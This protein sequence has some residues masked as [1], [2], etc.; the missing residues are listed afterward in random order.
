MTSNGKSKWSIKCIKLKDRKEIV[1]RKE[2]N[3]QEGNNNNN[4][5]NT[6]SAFAS[7]EREMSL[8]QEGKEFVCFYVCSSNGN[9]FSA[10]Y[11]FEREKLCDMRNEILIWISWWFL[12]KNRRVHSSMDASYIF[13]GYHLFFFWLFCY[14]FNHHH[15]PLRHRNCRW[16]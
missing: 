15:H 1:D 2:G 16:P 4:D 7:V 11:F 5:R 9:R 8:M 14:Y 3:V 10:E 6:A 12:L 13:Y